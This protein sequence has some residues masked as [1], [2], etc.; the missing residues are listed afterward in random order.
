MVAR[1][2][3]MTSGR[4][5]MEKVTTEVAKEILAETRKRRRGG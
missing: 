2:S 4:E 5:A 1:L 3:A